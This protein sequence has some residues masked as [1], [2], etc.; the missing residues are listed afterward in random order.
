M[1][2]QYWQTLLSNWRELGHDGLTIPYIL[3]AKRYCAYEDDNLSV[4]ELIFDIS[5]NSTYQV[6]LSY[7][8]SIDQIILGIRD[9]SKR[10]NAGEFLLSSLNENSS[11]FISKFLDDFKRDVFSVGKELAMRFQDIVDEGNFSFNNREWGNFTSD[12]LSF[13]RSCFANN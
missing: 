3:G 1:G 6:Y 8:F 9:E 5:T 12:E 2:K 13:I 4:E 7:C 10:N 11:L